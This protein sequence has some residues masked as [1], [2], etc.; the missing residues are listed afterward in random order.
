MREVHGTHLAVSQG[1]EIIVDEGKMKIPQNPHLEIMMNEGANK[2][3]HGMKG[4]EKRGQEAGNLLKLDGFFSQDLQRD[5]PEI[6]KRSACRDS[7]PADGGFSD[8]S[9]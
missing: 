8:D 6:T 1:Q 4:V 7:R 9:A 5:L 2:T 3:V